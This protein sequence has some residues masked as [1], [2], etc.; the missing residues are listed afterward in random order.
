MGGGEMSDTPETDGITF[1]PERGMMPPY[2]TV[3]AVVSQR[4]ERERNKFKT[5]LERIRDNNWP[6]IG[7][8]PEWAREVAR[9]ALK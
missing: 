9:E 2:K 7:D 5:A 3:P 1:V 6:V 8:R 4:L